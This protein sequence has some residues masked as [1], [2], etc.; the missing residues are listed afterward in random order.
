MLKRILELALPI[1]LESIVQMSFNGVDQIIV[2][3]LGASAVAAVGLSNSVA[4][5]AI[6]SCAAIG[7]GSGVLI[8]QAYGRKDMND[9]SRTAA[10]GQTL[11][12]AF[13]AITALPLIIFP[14][15]LLV[16]IGAH[17]DLADLASGYFVFFAASLPVTILSSV[18]SGAFRSL[19]D[20]KT[21]MTITIASVVLKPGRAS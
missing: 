1:S 17:D 18:T 10:V 4:A 20:S 11:A 14:K 8:A 16:L 12:G 5:I 19:N 13:G 9:V 7:T 3:L 15:P 6:L 21:P 2:G